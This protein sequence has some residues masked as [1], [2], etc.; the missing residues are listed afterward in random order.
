MI[1]CRPRGSTRSATSWAYIAFTEYLLI[2]A[3]DLPRQSAW[4]IVRFEG[5]WYVVSWALV[6]LH[7]ALPFLCLLFRAVKRRPRRLAAVAVLLLLMRPVELAWMLLPARGHLPGA[8]ILHWLDLALPLAFAALWIAAFLTF[9]L[10]G[11]HR[12]LLA[13]PEEVHHV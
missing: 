7:F 4:Y 11:P 12:R 6:V 5:P 10:R 1:P 2:W 3:A 9:A 8:P 13:A